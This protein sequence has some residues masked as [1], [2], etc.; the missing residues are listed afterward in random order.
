M[1]M[2]HVAILTGGPSA[3]RGISEKSAQCV[4]TYLD[5]FK[6]TYRYIVMEKE[7]WFEKSTGSRVD[8]NDFSLIIDGQREFFDF[9]FL[10]IHGTPAEDGKIQG[11]FEYL[12]IPH[13]TCHTLTASLTFNKQKCKDYLS[14]HEVAMAPSMLI[15][16]GDQ[17]NVEKFSS[18][19]LPLF[20]K[21]NNNGS[22]YGI[23]KVKHYDEMQTA[24]RKAL[25]YDTEVVVE[26]FLEGREFGCGIV[27]EGDHLHVFPITEIIPDA[28]FFTYEAK[29]EGASEEITP[30]VLPDRLTQEC[31]EISRQ[32]YHILDCRGMVRFDYI[33]VG[34]TFYLLEANT[35]PGMSEASIIPQQ[36][37]A[38]GWSITKL[39]DI[40]IEDCLAK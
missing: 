13:S 6:Y 22:S 8:L 21:P 2:I 12:R 24:I 9:V 18:L 14:A 19:G 3:E 29:Y 33:L 27:K 38:Y 17:W 26:A 37:Q 35:I 36:A 25:Q 15:K 34:E 30:A 5:A 1:Q 10:M 23:S 32:V 39:L 31:Q 20:V 7:G 4:A 40:V 11:Y 28:E 16:D